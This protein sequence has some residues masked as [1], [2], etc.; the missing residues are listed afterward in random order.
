VY[1]SHRC[2]GTLALADHLTGSQQGRQYDGDKYSFGPTCIHPLLLVFGFDLLPPFH[3]VP[4][5]P[6]LIT[7]FAKPAH[8]N[9]YLSFHTGEIMRL[10]VMEGS[11]SGD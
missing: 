10:K 4:R 2:S 3:I 6:G 8:R 7:I 1:P 5:L 9:N 11:H